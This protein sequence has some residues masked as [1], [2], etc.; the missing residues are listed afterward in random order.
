MDAFNAWCRLEQAGKADCFL[1][2]HISF[3]HQLGW[4]LQ[5][6]MIVQLTAAA[7]NEFEASDACENPN[8]RP[9][10]QIAGARTTSPPGVVPVRRPPTAETTRTFRIGAGARTRSRGCSR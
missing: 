2:P 8:V 9:A 6:D 4:H 3:W 1:A 7:R 10:T 5:Y